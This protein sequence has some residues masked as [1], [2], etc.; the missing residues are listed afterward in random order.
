M[1]EKNYYKPHFGPEETDYQI[2]AEYVRVKN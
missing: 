1:R 2:E